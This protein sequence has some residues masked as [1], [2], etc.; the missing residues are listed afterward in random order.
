MHKK[1]EHNEKLKRFL[2]VY[3][4]FTL[5]PTVRAHNNVKPEPEPDTQQ[6]RVHRNHHAPETIQTHRMRRKESRR[7]ETERST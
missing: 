5:A 6:K 2:T 1:N 7:H 4:W 3:V